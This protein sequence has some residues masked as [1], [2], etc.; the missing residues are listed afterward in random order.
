MVRKNTWVCQRKVAKHVFLSMIEWKHVLVF[1][2]DRTDGTRHTMFIHENFEIDLEGRVQVD[3]SVSLSPQE[4][5]YAA[6][7][8]SFC[9]ELLFCFVEDLLILHENRRRC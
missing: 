5:S 9:I 1:G 3:I 2:A 7:A 6:A 4:F 8:A